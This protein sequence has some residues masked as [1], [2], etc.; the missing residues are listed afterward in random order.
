MKPD[1]H[2]ETHAEVTDL[3]ERRKRTPAERAAAARQARNRQALQKVT[4]KPIAVVD[5]TDEQLAAGARAAGVP[6]FAIAT[7][8]VA[9]G[10]CLSR[11]SKPTNWSFRR[12]L[13]SPTDV[14]H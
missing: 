11:C 7:F 8:I 12:V 4:G 14:T 5:V 6:E 10:C 2:V 13:R 1:D 9:A 3:S